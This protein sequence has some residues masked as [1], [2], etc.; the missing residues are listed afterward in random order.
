MVPI[1]KRKVDLYITRECDIR[2]KPTVLEGSPWAE[3][4]FNARGQISLIAEQET[5]RNGGDWDPDCEGTVITKNI[6]SE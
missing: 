4:I 1:I 2:D 3:A 6:L 5:L